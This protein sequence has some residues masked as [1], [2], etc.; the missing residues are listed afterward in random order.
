MY[1]IYIRISMFFDSPMLKAASFKSS[2]TILDQF[3]S[4]NLKKN[5]V[6]HKNLVLKRFNKHIMYKKKPNYDIKRRGTDRL[7]RE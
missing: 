4:D 3:F 7:A 6:N 2:L 1:P 5:T